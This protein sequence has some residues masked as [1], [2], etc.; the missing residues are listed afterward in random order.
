MVT[1][2]PGGCPPTPGSSQ[3]L[4]VLEELREEL[5]STG[6]LTLVL[7]VEAQIAVLHHKLE[8]DEGGGV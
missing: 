3:L 5:A 4:G 1:N 6:K 8:F 2:S 7:P